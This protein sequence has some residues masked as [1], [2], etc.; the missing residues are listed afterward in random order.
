[1]KKL[2]TSNRKLINNIIF[3]CGGGQMKGV[4]SY[5]RY[6]AFRLYPNS[7]YFIIFNS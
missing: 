6:T 2:T 5:D 7:K 4:G 3:Q 1:M